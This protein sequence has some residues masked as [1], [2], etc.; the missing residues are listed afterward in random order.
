MKT[1]NDIPTCTQ[2]DI[3]STVTKR[4]LLLTLNQI[5]LH[6]K[7][8]YNELLRELRPISPKSLAD[9][10]TIMQKSRLI[11]KNVREGKRTVVEY[12]L[13]SNGKELRKS[14]KPLLKWALVHTNHGG[15]PI[16]RLGR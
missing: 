13:N 14:V 8:H 11:D 12:S 9:I 6:D 1:Q 15:C 7:I 10:L 5:G 16:L 4:W 3:L 2:R